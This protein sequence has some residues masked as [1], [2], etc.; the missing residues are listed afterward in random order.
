MSKIQK[1]RTGILSNL[2]NIHLSKMIAAQ[3]IKPK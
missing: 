1:E 2:K 3:P